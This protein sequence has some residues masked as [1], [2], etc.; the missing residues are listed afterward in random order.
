MGKFTATV[1]LT[2]HVYVEVE[3]ENDYTAHD[4]A[5]R[6]AWR[7]QEKGEGMWGEE[8]MVYELTEGESK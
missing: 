8:P 2:Y 5:I 6:E 4:K 3:A 7:L 1:R